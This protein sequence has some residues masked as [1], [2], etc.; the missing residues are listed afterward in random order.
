MAAADFVKASGSQRSMAAKS[1][2]LAHI[3]G[4][5]DQE[6]LHY[7]GQTATQQVPAATQVPAASGSS[8][9]LQLAQQ[10]APQ[11]DSTTRAPASLSESATGADSAGQR[12]V[13]GGQ[14][15][16]KAGPGTTA[17]AAAAAAAAGAGAAV[18]Q[19]VL[20]HPDVAKGVTWGTCWGTAAAGE[21]PAAPAAPSDQPHQSQFVRSQTRDGWQQWHSSSKDVVVEQQPEVDSFR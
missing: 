15:S 6:G 2:G 19:Q 1:L 20:P 9:L 17:A 11:L 4:C 18:P 8:S 14:V 21:L 12:H 16:N 10:Q 13:E 7:H 3:Y 5:H